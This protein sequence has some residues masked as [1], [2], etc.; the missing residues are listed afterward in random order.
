MCPKVSGYTYFQQPRSETL[1]NVKLEYELLQ[2][3]VRLLHKGYKL[4]IGMI[5]VANDS[6]RM[7]T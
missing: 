7:V 2:L 3:P 4:W 5:P 6:A 1:K